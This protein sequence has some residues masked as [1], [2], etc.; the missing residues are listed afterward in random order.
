MQQPL[1]EDSQNHTVR[2]IEMNID[3]KQKCNLLNALKLG[4]AL[5]SHS[6]FVLS[7]FVSN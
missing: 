3:E 6:L 5:T 2:D 7:L 1:T 4:Q